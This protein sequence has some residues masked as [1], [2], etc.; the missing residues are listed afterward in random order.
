VP[1]T[2]H[3]ALLLHS[4]PRRLTSQHLS[5]HRVKTKTCTGTDNLTSR[6]FSNAKVS[7]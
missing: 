4:L 3:T 1:F 7:E 2:V 6:A 5:T